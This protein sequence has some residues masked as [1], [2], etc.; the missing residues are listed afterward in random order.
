M[1]QKDTGIWL[2]KNEKVVGVANPKSI[3]APQVAGK[4]VGS[5]ALKAIPSIKDA[6][7]VQ[8]PA[9]VKTNVEKANF[10]VRIWRKIF[11]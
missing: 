10:F 7:G 4:R 5:I 6:D 11:G 3:S 8:L 9:T 1:L 2:S